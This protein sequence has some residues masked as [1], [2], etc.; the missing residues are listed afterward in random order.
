MQQYAS[1]MS[2]ALWL[3]QFS[4]PPPVLPLTPDGPVF[5]FRRCSKTICPLSAP[6]LS[7]RGSYEYLQEPEEQAVFVQHM[8]GDAG[9]VIAVQPLPLGGKSQQFSVI[10]WL[11]MRCLPAKSRDT[12]HQQEAL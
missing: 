7:H 2:R 12:H 8:E 11:H 5:P 4:P 9:A 10:T 6:Q 3:S 1:G